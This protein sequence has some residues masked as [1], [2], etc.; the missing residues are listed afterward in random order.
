MNKEFIYQVDGKDY[1]VVVT[2]K[3]IRSIHYRFDGKKFLVSSP[4]LMPM[5]HI[6]SGLDKFAKRLINLAPKI[7]P[8]GEDYIYIF[9]QRYELTYPGKIEVEGN[10]I[11]FKDEKDLL[12]KLKKMFLEYMNKRASYFEKEMGTASYIVKVRQMKSRYGS[13]S[14][15]TRTLTYGLVLMHYAKETIDSVIVHELAHYFVYNHSNS[16]YNIV[17][18]Y[19]PRYDILRKKLIHAEFN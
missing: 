13:N 14:V 5:K 12:R 3:R 15:H 6:V 17:Y 4:K 16:F 8:I 1:L 18:K 7:L 11:S 19:C 2:Y 9:G 10:L